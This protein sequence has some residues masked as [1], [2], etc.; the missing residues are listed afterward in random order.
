[1]RSAVLALHLW[2]IAQAAPDGSAVTV[3][4]NARWLIR[5]LGTEMLTN[6]AGRGGQ[7][8]Q[9]AFRGQRAPEH[10]GGAVAVVTGATGGIGAEVAM[11]L[12]QCGYH[13]VVAARDRAR[14][15]SLVAKLKKCGG[16]AEF[17]ELHAEQ[18]ASAAALA[19]SLRG[20]PC[21]LVINNAGV[22]GVSKWEI[23]ATNY[24]GPAVLTLTLLPLLRQH[25]S[26]RVVNVGSSSHLRAARVEPASL[27]SAERDGDLCA[28]AQSKLGLMQFSSL[29]RTS[30]PWLTVVDAHPGLVWTP[31]LQRHWGKLSPLLQRSGVAR[32][33]FKQPEC[34]AATILAAALSP[35]EPPA[36]WG[37]R[38]RW[39]RDWATQPYFVNGRPGGFA[40]AE[41]RDVVAARAAWVSLL[42]PMVRAHAP[43]GCREVDGGLEAER[44]V[45]QD[46]H[47]P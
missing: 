11:G 27:Q 22:M 19:T 43:D 42:R 47:E 10:G 40:S 41:S 32:C 34:G 5:G 9:R 28:Y 33:L 3:Y 30:L 37:E 20:R 21:A 23:M 26:P 45:L 38:T 2:A 1:M 4:R 13:V 44:R 15:R 14:G 12:A 25:A 7:T 35:Q 18:P 6:V 17:V 29:L 16:A 39:R 8:W 46:K 36:H 31:M 24:V